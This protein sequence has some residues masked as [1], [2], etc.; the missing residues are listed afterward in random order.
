MS[1]K[2]KI[3]LSAM[4]I[5]AEQGYE[6][7]TIKKIAQRVGVTP[8]AIYAFFNNKEDLFLRICKDFLQSHFSIAFHNKHKV[9]TTS[10]KVQL[11]QILREIFAF[12]WKKPIEIKVFMRLVLFPPDIIQNGVLHDFLQLEKNELHIFQ[13]IIES[14]MENGE[15]RKGNSED[16]A[17]FLLCM[18]DGLFWQMQRLDEADF[19]QRFNII[20]EQLWKGIETKRD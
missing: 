2:E 5:F 6:G 15:I 16:T 20:W 10:A 17:L 4:E 7:M 18:M 1:T 13:T 9:Q 12:Q 11:E 3:I 8:P 19:Q 14:G